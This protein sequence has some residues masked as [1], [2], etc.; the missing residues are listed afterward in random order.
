VISF[1]KLS[2]ID[3]IDYVVVIRS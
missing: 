1:E 2:Y 3:T